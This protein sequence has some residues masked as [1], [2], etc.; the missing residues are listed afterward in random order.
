MGVG[1]RGVPRH[2]GGAV[3]G[4]R[5]RGAAVL[6]AD[7]ALVRAPGLLLRVDVAG[8]RTPR[9]AHGDRGQADIIA[10]PHARHVEGPRGHRCHIPGLG[11]V[12]LGQD[13]R[14]IRQETGHE[15]AAP[16]QGRRGCR[17]RD[18]GRRR[19]GRGPRGGRRRRGRGPGGGRGGGR[20][21]RG[22]GPRGGRGG[23]RRRRGRGPCG[24]RGGRRRRRG[25]GARGGRGGGRRRRRRRPRGG[26]GGGGRRRGRGRGGG[27]GGRRRGR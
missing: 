2:V 9:A 14:G 22:R 24:G 7:Q 16:G 11:H 10:R 26:R 17:P 23:G 18:G 12:G 20:R 27:R 5:R 8:I 15:A 13:H 19:R 4:E 21:R 3:E 25:R 1:A 6:D